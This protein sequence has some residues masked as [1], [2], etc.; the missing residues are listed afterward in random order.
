MTVSEICSVQKPSILL[1]L[2]WSSENHQNINAQ[3]LKN[4]GAA[5]I[6]D[7]D[8]SN[9]IRLLELLINLESDHNRLHSM[10]HSASKVFPKFA[11]KNIYKS[12]NESLTI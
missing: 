11:S 9:S 6:I 7:S 4:R 12:I 5:E 3:Y 8:V 10:A 2:P 1:P